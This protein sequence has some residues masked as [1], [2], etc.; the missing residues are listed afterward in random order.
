MSEII[1]KC[2]NCKHHKPDSELNL[3][4]R[5][6]YTHMD[7]QMHFDRPN[8]EPIQDKKFS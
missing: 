1:R 6:C 7:K 3:E 5:P 8:F 2:V 4:C